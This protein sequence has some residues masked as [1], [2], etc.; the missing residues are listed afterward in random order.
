M[1]GAPEGFEYTA[2]DD[3]VEIRHHG[4]LAS[5]LRKAAAAK[6]LRDVECGDRQ[7]LMA[8]VTGNYKHGNE[9]MQRRP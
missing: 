1:A 8:R 4:T 6:F 3:R 5:T 7:Q 9:R 2:R